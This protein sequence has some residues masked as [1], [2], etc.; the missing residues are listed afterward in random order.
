MS[1]DIDKEMAAIMAKMNQADTDFDS[2]PEWD[3]EQSPFLHGVVCKVRSTEQIRRGQKVEVRLA[4]IQTT[5]EQKF[6]LWESANLGEFFDAIGEG[7][8]VLVEFVE[9]MQLKGGR[10]LKK[11]NAFYS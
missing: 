2:Y 4:I 5:D 1:T 11:Y 7:M 10:E 8:E 9:R 6:T 3:F